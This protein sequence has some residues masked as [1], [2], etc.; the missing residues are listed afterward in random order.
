MRLLIP[1]I[2]ANIVHPNIVKIADETM[3][4]INQLISPTRKLLRESVE[5]SL[6]NKM[7]CYTIRL[8]NL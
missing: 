6:S 4:R 2:V 8:I 7:N 1:N 5:H 3:G